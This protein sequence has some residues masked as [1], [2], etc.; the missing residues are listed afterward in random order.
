MIE[1]TMCILK[2]GFK[3]SD[4]KK[5][6]YVSGK[7]E[8]SYL[9]ARANMR[10]YDNEFINLTYMNSV[11]LRWILAKNI[12]N[13]RFM[14]KSFDFAYFIPYINKMLKYVVEREERV[15][16]WIAEIDKKVL[17]IEDWQVRLSDFMFKNNIH[18]FS[19]YQIKRFVKSVE[20]KLLK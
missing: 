4:K 12:S 16:R 8:Y 2:I 17:E 9:D 5:E 14:N 10:I 18:N 13:I 6:F 15:A 20:D 3:E 11:Y 19:K 1:R 7:K